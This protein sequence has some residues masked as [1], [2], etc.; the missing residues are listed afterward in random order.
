MLENF[1]FFCIRIGS[2]HTI[3]RVLFNFNITFTIIYN[4]ICDADELINLVFT[5]KP[6]Y[7][8]T[9]NDHSKLRNKRGN[10]TVGLVGIKKVVLFFIIIIIIEF[11]AV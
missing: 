8:C 9:D 2:M 1:V 4:G 10:E 5:R 3:A 6:I 11:I 7:D